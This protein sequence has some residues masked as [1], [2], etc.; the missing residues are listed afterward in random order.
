MRKLLFGG[1]LI[2]LLLLIPFYL[3]VYP[4]VATPVMVYDVVIYG[5]G[6]AGCA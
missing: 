3:W 4:Y 6:F 1:I 5:G 2:L